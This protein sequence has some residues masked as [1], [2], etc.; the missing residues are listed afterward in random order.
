MGKAIS[1]NYHNPYRFFF[2]EATLNLFSYVFFQRYCMRLQMYACI[3]I[4]LS[5]YPSIT[6]R[7]QGTALNIFF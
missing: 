1:L 6:Y 3:S 7:H 4:Y 2:L 5:I